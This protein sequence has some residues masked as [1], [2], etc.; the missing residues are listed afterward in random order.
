MSASRKEKRFIGGPNLQSYNKRNGGKSANSNAGWY[1][2]QTSCSSL[3]TV[4]SQDEVRHNYINL[5]C[6]HRF[7][8]RLV[9]FF[10]VP[11]WPRREMFLCDVWRTWV[12]AWESRDIYTLG[13]GADPGFFL[14][15][16]CTR[17]L[18][19]FN[20][21]KP[22]SFFWQNTSC[23]RKPRVISGGGVISGAPSP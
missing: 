8:T 6:M 16:G 14:G 15:G 11:A 9:H 23:I 22:H 20:T 18:L 1:E 7:S 10:A 13:S 5:G 2:E 19:C 4:F 21:N 3:R 17:L 12:Q